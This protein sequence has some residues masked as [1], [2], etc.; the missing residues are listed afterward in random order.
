MSCSRTQHNEAGEALTHGPSVSSQ[1]L[2]IEPLCSH[3]YIKSGSN[4]KVIHCC[5][6]LSATRYTHMK[7]Q[8]FRSSASK[9]IANIIVIFASTHICTD[10]NNMHS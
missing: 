7:S 10:K 9:V 1:A 2:S 3:M 4:V 5:I 8:R 6:Y